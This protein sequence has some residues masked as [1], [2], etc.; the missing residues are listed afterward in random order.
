MKTKKAKI[1][2]LPWKHIKDNRVSAVVDSEGIIVCGSLVCSPSDL[3][4]DAANHEFIV[5]CVNSVN[6]KMTYIKG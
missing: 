2:P 5:K 4:T 3:K 1:Q 6:N